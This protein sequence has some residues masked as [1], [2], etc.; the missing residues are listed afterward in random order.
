MATVKLAAVRTLTPPE[1]ERQREEAFHDWLVST[2]TAYLE[3]RNGRHIIPGITDRSTE[4]EVREGMCHVESSCVRCGTAIRTVFGVEDGLLVGRG[5]LKS[6]DYPEGYLL[7]K[8]AT[9]PGGAA[10]DKAHRAL[11]RLE[12]L[13]RGLRTRGTSLAK[14]IAKDKKR[15]ASKSARDAKRNQPPF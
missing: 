10:M 8:E 15:Q 7:P 14:E 12:I 5:R 6:Y 13:N 9:G 1:M 11:V 2:A 3:C 4:L